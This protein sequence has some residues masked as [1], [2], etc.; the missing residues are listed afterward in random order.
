MLI[1]PSFEYC[2]F[3][4]LEQWLE[5][6][7]S[8]FSVISVCPT[9]ESIREALQYFGVSRNFAGVSE[10]EKQKRILQSLLDSIN[11]EALLQ[12]CE[13]VDALADRFRQEF[14]QRNLS[15]ASKLLWLSK[16][17]PFV[18]YDSRAVDALGEGYGNYSAFSRAWR[19]QYKL[20]KSSIEE[21]VMKLPEASVF[22]RTRPSQSKLLQIIGETWFRERVF[23]IYLWE[24]GA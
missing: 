18:I 22:L 3:K 6:E 5:S 7:E 8:L 9:P 24:R 20:H 15:A 23:D 4:F 13:K 16:R 2:A 12:P 19:T 21:A 1:E 10:T 11:D 14:N 17:D